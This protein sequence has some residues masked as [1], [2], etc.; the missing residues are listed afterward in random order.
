MRKD[1]ITPWWQAALLPEV[2][3]VAGFHIP[4]LSVWHVYALRNVLN[5]YAL[6]L[7]VTDRDDATSLI[8]IASNDYRDGKRLFL[9]PC[10]RERETTALCA[11]LFKLDWAPLD[12][13]CRDYVKSCIRTADRWHYNDPKPA[14]VPEAWHLVY[15]LTNGNPS[16]VEQ[17]WNTPYAVACCMYDAKAEQAGDDTIRSAAAQEMT[18]TWAENQPK[19]EPAKV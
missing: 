8:L 12:S 9:D 15:S 11:K 3:D 10:R 4:S 1:W 14:G 17:A 18:D 16:L 19:K 6:K 2:W 5:G 7:D 13:A